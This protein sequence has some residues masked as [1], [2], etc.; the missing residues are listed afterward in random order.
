[1]EARIRSTAA[2]AALLALSGAMSGSGVE[3]QRVE[4]SGGWWEV[5]TSGWHVEGRVVLGDR[6]PD[7][8]PP[9]RAQPVYHWEGPVHGYGTVTYKGGK[10]PPRGGPA[11]C[12]SGAGHPVHGWRWC[13]D[14]GYHRGPAWYRVSP[15]GIWFYEMGAPVG[16]TFGV[17]TL[18][19]I[20]GPY[21]VDDLYGWARDLGARGTLQG[22]WVPVNDR[23]MRVLQVRA[24]SMP[25]AEFTDRNG[26]RRVDELLVYGY[27]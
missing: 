23:R 14:R 22:R 4:L 18:E 24:G 27:R 1:M 12:E 16:R 21:V 17:R 2:A 7:I 3:A 26:N 20:L 8:P 13:A 6:Y 25:V 5:G 10:R 9:R 19:A 15:R 11:F